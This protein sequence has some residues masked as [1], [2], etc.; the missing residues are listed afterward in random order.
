MQVRTIVE[1]RRNG[2]GMC[3]NVNYFEGMSRR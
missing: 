2:T 3:K 1:V